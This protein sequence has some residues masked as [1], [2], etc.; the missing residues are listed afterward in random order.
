MTL[1][2]ACSVAAQFWKAVEEFREK[3]AT[4]IPSAAGASRESVQSAELG[5]A[6]KAASDILNAAQQLHTM[7]VGDAAP[8]QIN[9]PDDVRAELDEVGGVALRHVCPMRHGC[10][11]HLRASLHARPV[12][13]PQ[14]VE[15]GDADEFMFD[16]AQEEIYKLM[17]SDNYAR[18]KKSELFEELMA[19]VNPYEGDAVQKAD[20]AKK[21][22]RRTTAR[23]V[24]RRNAVR[25]M[26]CASRR[27][28]IRSLCPYRLCSLH[29]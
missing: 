17:E 8:E 13:A 3:F 16:Q 1:W 5:A 9:I 24:R 6:A 22:A 20:S 18:F 14:R 19:V 11:R 28:L 12:W 10:S 4:Q 15:S 25:R 2:A 23:R 27:R 7:Y 29:N 26:C 21:M